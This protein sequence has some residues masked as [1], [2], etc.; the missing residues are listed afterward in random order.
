L[1]GLVM[2]PHA[3][4]AELHRHTGKSRPFCGHRERN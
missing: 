4:C 1:R 2:I 3:Q